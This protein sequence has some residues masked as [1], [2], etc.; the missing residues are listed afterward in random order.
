VWADGKSEVL[1]LPALRM[2]EATVVAAV[3]LTFAVGLLGLLYVGLTWDQPHR[4]ELAALFV[5]SSVTSLGTYKV[6]QQ[7]VR[8]RHREA[9]FLAWTLSDFAMIVFGALVDGGTSSPLAAIFLLPVVFSAISYPLGSVV[10]V[11]MTSVLGYLGVAAI[12]G[13][14]PL[15]YEVSFAFTLV[16]TAALS[17][18]QSQN[19]NRQHRALATASRTDPLTGCLNRRGF[20]E[21]AEAELASLRRTG[22]EGAIL[23]LDV[24]KFKP[25]NDVFGHAA[26]DEL[27]CWVVSTL[28]STVRQSDAIGRLGGDEFAIVLPEIP[29]EEV[30]ALST[31]IGEALAERAPCSFG[32]ALYP[33]DG[34][35][36]EALTR[37]AD[38]RL[39]GSRRGRYQRERAVA[40]AS[41][42]SGAMA[43]ARAGAEETGERDGGGFGAIDLWR[44][45]LD[46]MP[47]RAGRARERQDTLQSMLLDQIDAS[48]IA[49]DMTGVVISWNHGAEALYG[50][51]AEEA[52]GR[53]ARDLVVPEDAAAA[54]RLMMELSRDGRWDGELLVRRKDGTLF[55]TYVRNRLVLDD[56][57]IASAVVGV[58][59]DI[60]DRVAAET[61]LRDSRNY[62]QAVTEC[63]GEGL[64][65]VDR[66][67]L[68]TYTN[69]VAEKLLG[70]SQGELLG[71]HLSTMI[72]TPA[73][74]GSSAPF[75]H[76]AIT[77]AL[78]GERTV[79]IEDDRFATGDGGELPVA[80]TATPFTTEGGPQGCV[81]IFQDVSERKRRED[82][83]RRNAETLAVIDRVEKALADGRFVL[84]AQPIVDLASGET[85]QHE[86]LVRMVEPD[87]RIVPPAEFLPVC[88][89]YAM[90]G[91]IDW[92]VIKQATR[93][94]GSGC[95]VQANISARSVGDPDVLEHI[96]R[97]VEQYEV[98]RGSLVFE[99]TETTIV[100]DEGAARTF[101]ER[102]R[103]LGCKIALDDFG[104]GYASLTYLKQMPVDFLKLDIEFVRDLSVSA[105]SRHVVQAL[106]ALARDFGLQT[107]GEGVE[108]AA[109]LELLAELG[110]D[111]AQGY[112]IA[113]PAPFGERP[114]D[115]A[116]G[117]SSDAEASAPPLGAERGSGQPPA[118]V[119]DAG[120]ETKQPRAP[121]A[122]TRNGRPPGRRQP[123]G[124]RR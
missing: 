123:A 21:R 109:T 65:T 23:V 97:C 72:Y 67:G 115:G 8:S 76:R 19:H 89:Q 38:A 114:G 104:T 44:A 98:P 33:H 101:A 94:A 81:V 60:S 83:S 102:L 34:E 112:H 77:R 51:S 43:A 26:G 118:A 15:A 3:P 11:G 74:D 4:V 111:A 49:T 10:A 17:G 93:L 61:A 92:W 113:R 40:G 121:A 68:I 46:A 42:D 103:R 107:V 47:S 70:R 6:R 91:E 32:V 88:E 63:M 117:D 30:R 50:W 82:E 69:G 22:R 24:D 5:F 13:G 2:R 45:A 12:E 99:I 27:L 31:R 96:E 64:F 90:I 56:E 120:S 75:E 29:A 73:A 1:D 108:D 80:Y 57:G 66:D 48:V 124:A 62:V 16:C 9:L 116:A 53:S 36:L 86:L 110:V 85:V 35:D 106:V 119:A 78:R 87:G 105:A 20:E 54:E 58:A 28:Q 25:V 79:R 95:P 18:W 39:Y 122:P 7:M 71:C 37:Q 59:V 41:E 55:T 84:H 52:I 14:Q 100:E